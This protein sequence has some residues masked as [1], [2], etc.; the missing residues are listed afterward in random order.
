MN[1]ET[2]SL[3]AIKEN[4]KSPLVLII[5]DLETNRYVLS[6]HL[7]EAGYQVLE[8]KDGKEAL[9]LS[10]EHPDLILL[11]VKL[12]DFSGY[13]ICARLKAD[14]ETARIPVIL[15]SAA[16]TTGEDHVRGIEGGADAYLIT[17]T[18]PL[19]LLS[20][21]KAW[22]RVRKADKER[23]ILLEERERLVNKLATN[24]EHLS[25]ALEASLMG[26]WQVDL[27]TGEMTGSPQLASIY[28]V[29]EIHGNVID[30][31]LHPDDREAFNRIWKEAVQK[32]NPY[33]HQFRIVLPDGN[34]K[35]IEA[36]GQGLTNESGNSF[37]GLS[38]DITELKE[39]HLLVE[40]DR[41]QLKEFFK[42]SPIP[43]VILLGEE[44]KFVIANVPYEKLV[45]R[46]VQ[47]KTLR[48]AFTTEEVGHFVP[49]L[50]SVY[51]TGIPY[52][53]KELPLNIPDNEGKI[54]NHWVNIIYQPFRNEEDGTIKGVLALVQDVT[55]QVHSRKLV[56]EV[57]NA[58]PHMVW[59][60][61][62]D[63]FVDWYNDRWYEY[64]GMERGSNWD[65]SPT[66]MHPDDIESIEKNWM[67][68][69][70]T[71]EPYQIHFRMKRASDGMY[72]WFMSRAVAIRDE[73]GNISKWIGNITDVQEHKQMVQQ[74]EDERELRERFVAALTHD[75]R[76]PLTAAK[77]SAQLIAR[78]NYDADS[79]QRNAIKIS[80]HIDRADQL[81][82]DLLDA[83][84]IS[85]GEKV[86]LNIQPCDL[87]KLTKDT[88]DE[89]ASVYGNRF[90]LN[91]PKKLDGF[92]S[93][94]GIR[95]ILENLCLNA[96]KYGSS[97]TPV[98]ISLNERTDLVE[99]KVHNEGQPI[100]MDDQAILFTQYRR[101]DSASKSNQKGWGLGLTLVKGI[102]EAHRG[103]IDVESTEETGTIFKIMLP[104]DARTL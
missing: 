84:R 41:N 44:H 50:D 13:D 66:A 62:L 14:V 71:G 49:L 22:L 60:A 94:S 37:I 9:K 38:V 99:L 97:Q 31:Q 10:K 42:Q 74:L 78:K 7:K 23:N 18:N 95:R 59:T 85:A 98:T 19:I 90:K 15:T 12:P 83:N 68:S 1:D 76:T 36:R 92:W 52:N 101:T 81:I 61:R 63:G 33:I 65:E 87:T 25:L 43:M 58:M 57:S 48:E 21:I 11:D 8:G 100:P 96:L 4:G 77:M 104:L 35:W 51:H 29:K 86:P 89:L 72:R 54:V 93:H 91:S 46:Q 102:A 30:M 67:H 2:Y 5:D 16:F 69:I 73:S 53:G 80:D 55:E 26:T 27:R 3:R 56:E 47:G 34:I 88:I 45:G 39:K 6:M 70:Q 20:T 75:L 32:E 40:H 82:R 28:G 64:T 24:Q 17:P 79:I 103:S